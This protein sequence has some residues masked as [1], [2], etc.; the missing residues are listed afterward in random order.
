MS[1]QKLTAL[2]TQTLSLLLERQRLQNISSPGRSSPAISSTL[3]LPQITR[4]LN[5]LRTG[6]LELESS[7]GESEAVEVLKNQ[8]DKMRSMLG[9]DGQQ[10]ERCVFPNKKITLPYVHTSPSII[11][12]VPPISVEDTLKP[13]SSPPPSKLLP[14]QNE[15]AFARYKDDPELGYEEDEGVML[16]TQRRLMDGQFS[17]QFYCHYYSN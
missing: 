2:S 15:H 11:K 8:Y 4:N 10:L 12:P 17:S 1:L 7:D 5:Q 3:H 6:I 14:T 13:D 9:V 16:Q